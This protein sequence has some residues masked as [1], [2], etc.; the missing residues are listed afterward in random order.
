MFS[1]LE[2]VVQWNDMALCWIIRQCFPIAFSLQILW[3]KWLATL[4]NTPPY[5]ELQNGVVTQ[6]VAQ[7][8][9][10]ECY[11]N[12]KLMQCYGAADRWSGQ[13]VVFCHLRYCYG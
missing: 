11:P 5:S 13:T 6:I 9:G 7:N 2:N 10:C 4:K 8:M 12:A 3:T 1:K